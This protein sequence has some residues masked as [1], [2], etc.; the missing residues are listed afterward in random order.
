MIR[1][2]STDALRIDL[3]TKIVILSGSRQRATEPV[4]KRIVRRFMWLNSKID[5]D[6][7]N[8]SGFVDRPHP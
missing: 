7:R 1:R 5:V 4:Q 3:D 2:D 6:A 8:S